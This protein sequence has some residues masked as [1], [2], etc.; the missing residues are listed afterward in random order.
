MVSNA[1]LC[2]DS[3]GNQAA[4]AAMQFEKTLWMP[5]TRLRLR[6][7]WKAEVEEAAEFPY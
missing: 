5:S 4:A 1:V 7:T 2:Q 3:S 6:L